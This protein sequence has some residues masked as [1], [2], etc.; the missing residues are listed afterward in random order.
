MKK[1]LFFASL[2]IVLSACNS[3]EPDNKQ[4]SERKKYV[5]EKITW[6]DSADNHR[7]AYYSYDNN[8][9]LISKVV[10][11]TYF[12]QGQV[13]H[14]TWTDTYEYQNNKLVRVNST[15][16]GELTFTYNSNGQLIQY[17]N[18]GG[19]I[20]FGYH[21]GRMDS[22]YAGTDPNVYAKLEY[23]SKGNVVK[24]ISHNREYGEIEE[25]TGN[26]IVRTNTYV[27]DNN[28]RPN[29]NTDECF[30]YDP[31]I[32][33][34]STAVDF[35]NLISANNMTSN[36][37]QETFTYSYDEQNGLPIELYTQFADIE[38][39]NHPT[40]KFTYRKIK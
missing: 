12:E 35:I 33:S 34:G 21:D 8:N 3:V 31:S 25:W 6:Y 9:R 30:A 19:L 15:I 13:K 36:S 20:N 10:E 38:P 24:V 28:P 37:I 1:L 23:D 22:I 29:F 32:T 7:E 26:Y 18:N 39:T 17:S 16:I 11:D 14:R 2:L 27:Y 40:Y 5:V 4:N